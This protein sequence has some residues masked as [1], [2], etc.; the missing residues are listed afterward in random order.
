MEISFVGVAGALVVF[1][2]A[3]HFLRSVSS[4]INVAPLSQ[5]WLAEQRLARHWS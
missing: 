2:V 5:Q 1:A 4:Q 3:R